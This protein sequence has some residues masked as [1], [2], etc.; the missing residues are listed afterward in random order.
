MELVLA[1]LKSLL[2]PPAPGQSED[3][4]LELLA[5]PGLMT[6]LDQALFRSNEGQLTATICSGHALLACWLDLKHQSQLVLQSLIQFDSDPVNTTRG[7]C[8][9][10]ARHCLESSMDAIERLSTDKFAQSAN[11]TDPYESL[12]SLGGYSIM[13]NVLSGV[14]VQGVSAAVSESKEETC[15]RAP[16]Q[17]RKECWESPRLICPDY[18]WADDSYVACQRWIRNL[19]KHP[20][21]IKETEAFTPLGKDDSNPASH[22]YTLSAASERQ[23]SLLIQLVQEDLPMRLYH[24]NQAMHADAVVTKR[25]YLVKSE[26]RAP[27]RAFLEAHQ[28]LLKAPPLEK[29]EACLSTKSRTGDD[30]GMGFQKLL[31]TPALVE[32]LALER[33]IEQLEENIGHALYPF[34]ELARTLDQRKARVKA[35]PGVIEQDQVQDL[36]NS[37]RVSFHC[38]L[39]QVGKLPIMSH[40]TLFEFPDSD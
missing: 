31:K 11:L 19:G 20:F 37:L 23:A 4:K 7:H 39:G 17:R 25:L 3:K 38:C 15:R 21:V 32:L 36:E 6:V 14:G 10:F 27:F 5:V 24:F 9:S 2:F 1:T 40:L 18:V 35:V 28:S 8:E 30:R 33:E 34:S 22:K 26:Y 12:S 13:S 16:M 29:V